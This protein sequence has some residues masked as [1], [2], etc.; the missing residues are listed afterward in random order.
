M[1]KIKNTLE[2]GSLKHNNQS[3]GFTGFEAKVPSSFLFFPPS[4][5]STT[6]V[7]P[8][9]CFKRELLSR[10]TLRHLFEKNTLVWSVVT[11]LGY[12]LTSSPLVSSGVLIFSTRLECRFLLFN[13]LVFLLKVHESFS[14]GIGNLTFVKNNGGRI[15]HSK[16]VEKM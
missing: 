7:S 1:R 15:L 11:S 2:K 10:S 4:T 5:L 6:L 8:T 12:S 9:C 16:R 3:H 14:K 13:F